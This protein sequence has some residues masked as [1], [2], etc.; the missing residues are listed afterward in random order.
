MRRGKCNGDVVYGPREAQL[1]TNLA[2]AIATLIEACTLRTTPAS[3]AK[4]QIID[5]VGNLT[6]PLS[7]SHGPE[8]HFTILMEISVRIFFDPIDLY[9]SSPVLNFRL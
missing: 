8:A 6:N 4:V 2:I 1:F 7:Q 3:P 5:F 9:Y